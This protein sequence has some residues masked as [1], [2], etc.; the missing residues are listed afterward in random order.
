MSLAHP[1]SSP[2]SQSVEPCVE[3]DQSGGFGNRGN[4]LHRLDLDNEIVEIEKPE[5]LV[6]RIKTGDLRCN[7]P[8]SVIVKR[9]IDHGEDNC[10]ALGPVG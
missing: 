5:E 3:Q 10:F 7:V 1:A 6:E 2:A 4:W 8:V 9:G